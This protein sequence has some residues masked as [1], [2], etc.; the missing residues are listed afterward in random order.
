MSRPTSNVFSAAYEFERDTSNLPSWLKQF[1]DSYS[2]KQKS[3]VEVARERNA[4]EA[5]VYERMNALINGGAEAP[6]LSPYATVDEAVQ[7]YHKRTGLT[8]YR[9][10]TMADQIMKA[11]EDESEKKTPEI[12]EKNPAIAT[13]INNIIDTQYGVQLPAILQSIVETFSRNVSES[14]VDNADLARYINDLMHSK[15]KHEDINNVNIGRGV[16]TEKN[17]YQINDGN[18]DPFSGLIPQRMF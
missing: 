17:Q 18:R 11:A 3:A 4:P 16:G 9:K 14:D 13:Y 6:K 1:A 8:E 2:A 10:K 5:S 7:D 15:R 12:L